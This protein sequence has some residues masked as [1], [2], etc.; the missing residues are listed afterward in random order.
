MLRRQCRGAAVGAEARVVKHDLPRRI[1]AGL[2]VIAR[3]AVHLVD[4]ADPLLW[5]GTT[6]LADAVGEDDDVLG[7]C[8]TLR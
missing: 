4:V 5:T 6:V 2:G 3:D 8:H 7:H 1:D